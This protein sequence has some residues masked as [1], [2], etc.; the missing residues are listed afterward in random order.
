MI[1][2][3][4]VPH[5]PRDKRLFLRAG[6]AVYHMHYRVW[7]MGRVVE[8]MTSTLPGGGAFVRID[9]NDGKRR[10]FNNDLDHYQCCYFFGLR[11]M[12]APA[13]KKPPPCFA[14]TITPRRIPL[15]SGN[16][17]DRESP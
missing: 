17:R 9:W 1:E 10:V 11:L 13:E 6:D 2:E 15:T 4:V 16:H 3:E 14:G 7:G 12:D 8:L 5:I